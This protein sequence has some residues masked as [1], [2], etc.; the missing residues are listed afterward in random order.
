M[1][2]S[3]GAIHPGGL[4]IKTMCGVAGQGGGSSGSQAWP[5]A[6]GLWGVGEGGLLTHRSTRLW[7]SGQGWV[8]LTSSPTYSHQGHPGLG[9]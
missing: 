4:L 8:G 5:T 7:C 1:A 2:F 9:P 3:Q 6:Y